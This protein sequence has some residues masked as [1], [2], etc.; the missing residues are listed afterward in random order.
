M[1]HVELYEE[2]LVVHLSTAQS[3]CIENA[4]AM[5]DPIFLAVMLSRLS[6]TMETLE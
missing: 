6:Q 5:L 1:M 4:F 3:K 2:P